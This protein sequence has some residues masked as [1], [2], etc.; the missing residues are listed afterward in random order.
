MTTFYLLTVSRACLFIGLALLLLAGVELSLFAVLGRTMILT[1]RSVAP[2]T[3]AV[4]VNLMLYALLSW[5]NG[6]DD[7]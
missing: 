7:L 3:A 4:V 5:L 6:E 2:L 1:E